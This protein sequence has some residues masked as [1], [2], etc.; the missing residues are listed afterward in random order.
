MG[1]QEVWYKVC[2]QVWV[3]LLHADQSEGPQDDGEAC[4]GG[5]SQSHAAVANLLFF[6]R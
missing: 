1:L 5:V 4:Q 3:S 6:T 2:L